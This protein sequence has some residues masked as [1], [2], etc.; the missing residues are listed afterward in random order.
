MFDVHIRGS[1]VIFKQSI[2]WLSFSP[3]T[4]PD[5]CSWTA[6]HTGGRWKPAAKEKT[7]LNKKKKKT[8]I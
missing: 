8:H 4:L 1:V 7:G 6:L 5:C 2:G 3:I